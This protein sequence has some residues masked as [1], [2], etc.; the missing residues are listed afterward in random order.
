MGNMTNQQLNGISNIKPNNWQRRKGKL[1]L[2]CK[3]C[4]QCVLDVFVYDDIDRNKVYGSLTA[5]NGYDVPLRNVLIDLY[6]INNE[7]IDTQRT[8]YGTTLA[9]RAGHVIFNK[10]PDGQYYIKINPNN[11]E[12]DIQANLYQHIYPTDP[13]VIIDTTGCDGATINASYGF[14]LDDTPLILT[15]GNP[16]KTSPTSCYYRSG[17]C[18]ISSGTI[19][20]NGAAAGGVFKLYLRVTGW[21]P[22]CTI[23]F[24]PAR[25]WDISKELT[26]HI[27][28]V[29]IYSECYNSHPS[30]NI[31]DS[32]THKHYNPITKVC[33]TLNYN[34]CRYADFYSIINYYSSPEELCGVIHIDYSGL[35]LYTQAYGLLEWTGGTPN[36]MQLAFFSRI[37]MFPA[38][39]GNYYTEMFARIPQGY[40]NFRF[41]IQRYATS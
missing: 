27:F 9:H 40:R 30:F 4:K 32:C 6:T 33:K 7:L 22:L 31:L 29:N 16:C 38:S 18:S 25:F 19:D 35:T 21:N 28:Y 3:A 13:S 20:G 2:G 14:Y 39:T 15:D 12:L 34:H 1:N 24:H 36:L 17:A 41:S 10:V 37:K 11:N 26:N 5:G 8:D 23:S